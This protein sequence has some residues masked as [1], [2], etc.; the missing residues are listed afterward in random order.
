MV[1][2]SA[3]RT[4]RVHGLKPPP[5]G[6]KAS[7]AAAHG[8]KTAAALARDVL[9]THTLAKVPLPPARAPA[10]GDSAAAGAGTAAAGDQQHGGAQQA[11]APAKPL[12]AA[13]FADESLSS[14]FRRLAW[15]PEGS[16]L[17]VPA[18]VYR[19]HA[20]QPAAHATYL[21]ARGQWGCP[22]AALPCPTKPSTVARFCP[23]LFSPR[24][25]GGSSTARAAAEGSVGAAA[26][27]GAGGDDSTSANDSSGT[28]GL[29]LPYRMVLAV[30]TLDSVLLYDTQVRPAAVRAW[31]SSLSYTQ[32]VA[33]HPDLHA[34]AADCPPPLHTALR[35]PHGVC[36]AAARFVLRRHRR[37]WSPCCWWAPSTTRPS[38]TL[39]GPGTARRSLCHPTTAT[40]AS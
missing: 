32:C 15:S 34:G 4:L 40:A 11:Q 14:F 6:S 38:Q 31:L 7:A 22:L 35:S 29:G 3:D 12:Q 2:Q 18:G 10:A 36:R 33:R 26:A 16:L 20:G 19:R 8:V 28:S 13:L 23:L 1:S 39:H 5:T 9:H 21:Y 17:A 27:G 24:P 37:R 25:A 30:A